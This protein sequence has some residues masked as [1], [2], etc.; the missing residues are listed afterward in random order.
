MSTPSTTKHHAGRGERS[1]KHS[2]S[3]DV[4]RSKHGSSKNSSSNASNSP[5][6]SFLFVVNELDVN[7]ELSTPESDQWGNILP[8]T[9]QQAYRDEL[10]GQVFRYDRG[11]VS[12]ADEYQWYRPVWG[13]AGGIIRPGNPVY[14]MPY[15]TQTVFACSPHLPI[16]VSDCDASLGTTWFRHNCDCDDANDGNTDSWN[17]LHFVNSNGV[18]QVN[19][20]SQGDQYVAG[21][22]PSWIPALVPRAFEDTSQ[23]TTPSQ[24]LGG[25]LPIVIA[26]MAFHSS[27]GR[28]SHVFS[29]RKWEHNEWRGSEHSPAGYPRSHGNPRG[30]LV[31]VAIERDPIYAGDPAILDNFADLEWT[32]LFVRG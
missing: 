32:T 20:S 1:H 19:A 23:N 4:K 10:A 15:K 5:G 11:T 16:I 6:L 2:S 24:G 8:P 27:R 25:E 26:L 22:N 28:A 9:H 3:K 29:S 12:P 14:A 18:S 7:F 31:H 17:S 13:M 30:L 21:R